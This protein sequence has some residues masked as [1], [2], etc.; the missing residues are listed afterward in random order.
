MIYVCFFFDELCLGYSKKAK[1]Y[2]SFVTSSD[3]DYHFTDMSARV[4]VL[5]CFTR[6]LELKYLV[7]DGS[8]LDFLLIQKLAKVLMILLCTHRN[9]PIHC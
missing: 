3:L 4:E 8:E 1:I 9:T 7:D 6:V 5:E 2:R